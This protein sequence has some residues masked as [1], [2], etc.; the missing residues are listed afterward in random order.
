LGGNVVVIDDHIESSA[1]EFSHVHV[2]ATV[3]KASP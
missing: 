3:L 1:S 2:W